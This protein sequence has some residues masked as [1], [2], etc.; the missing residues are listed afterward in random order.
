MMAP[1][2]GLDGAAPLPPPWLA[3]T[4]LPMDEHP[5]ASPLFRVYHAAWGPIFFGPGPGKPP[6]FRFDSAKGAFGVLY[7]SPSADGALV[8]TLLRRPARRFVDG[9]AEITPRLL[10]IL[11]ADHPLRLVRAW[12]DGLSR[13]GTTAALSTGPYTSSQVW[14]DAL[15]EHPDQ[16]DGI[17]FASRHNNQEICV[18]LFERASLTLKVVATQPLLSILSQ[19]GALL[20]RHGKA[21]TGI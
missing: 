18:A 12:G 4:P 3:T 21:L 19:V 15:F 8:E 17:A 9:P 16:P 10:S 11:E 7:A 20:D 1:S 13:L 2:A 14:A 5:K 6:A